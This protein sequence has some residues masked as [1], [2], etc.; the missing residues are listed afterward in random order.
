MRKFMALHRAGTN[1]CSPRPAPNASRCRRFS[2]LTDVGRGG[3]RRH[4]SVRRN[5]CLFSEFDRPGMSFPMFAQL[6][7]IPVGELKCCLVWPEP[8]S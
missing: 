1:A 2:A 7:P 5:A 6:S 8:N 4:A 3:I